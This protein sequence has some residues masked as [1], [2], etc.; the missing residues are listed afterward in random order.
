MIFL[1]YLNRLL[2]NSII[3]VNHDISETEEASVCESKAVREGAYLGALSNN[4]DLGYYCIHRP[5]KI[6]FPP[7]RK[8]PRRS[9]QIQ[10]LI[11]SLVLADKISLSLS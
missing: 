2:H 7:A 5:E 10:C 6:R 11:R 1:I 3:N 9:I 8:Y 4:V